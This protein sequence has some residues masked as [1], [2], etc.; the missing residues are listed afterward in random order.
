DLGRLDFLKKTRGQYL[1]D[2]LSLSP[3]DRLVHERERF[4]Q[5]AGER[6][7]RLVAPLSKTSFLADA[8]RYQDVSLEQVQESDALIRAAFLTS[9]L[10]SAGSEKQAIPF[11]EAHQLF[12][13]KKNDVTELLAQAQTAWEKRLTLLTEYGLPDQSDMPNDFKGRIEAI[14]ARKQKDNPAGEEYHDLLMDEAGRSLAEEAMQSLFAGCDND[15]AFRQTISQSFSLFFGDCRGV[16]LLKEG[17][18]LQVFSGCSDKLS[19]LQNMSI[20]LTMDASRIIGV[21]RSGEA[22]QWCADDLDPSAT[23][24][25][26][27]QLMS[28]LE[29][30]HIH[31]FPLTIAGHTEGV[32]ILG[33][34]DPVQDK[35]ARL[36]M[37]AFAST[38]SQTLQQS[39]RRL[40][41]QALIQ[42]ELTEAFQ[43]HLGV[44]AHEVKNPLNIITNYLYLLGGKL[45]E[46][47]PAQEH[48]T[49]ISTEVERITNILKQA[50]NTEFELSLDQVDINQT[51]E[52]Q[53]K[54]IESSLL[55]EKGV[56]T[57]LHLQEGLA[58]L[59]TDRDAIKQILVNLLKNAAEAV[60]KETGIIEVSTYVATNG[61]GER[62]LAIEVRDNGPG[63][64]DQIRSHLFE[65]VESTKGGEHS[66][67]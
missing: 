18:A 3:E 24:V 6:G 29:A 30:E 66:G 5:T 55:N 17:E 54:L 65:R 22:S 1:A 33:F 59:K 53:L 26:D 8:L 12:D 14:A 64:P 15:S 23:V 36:L 34:D 4:R 20:P 2:I 52:K 58:K 48:L 51:I 47:H 27:M 11:D 44:L 57:R 32:V 63:I 46:G 50:R 13:L 49:V 45:E 28:L 9:L 62:E 21:M 35:W 40:D 61:E 56:S 41:Q 39:R 7:S 25:Q 10:V 19:L 16:V 38:L 31:A 67:V 60:A 37:P 43:S 42:D